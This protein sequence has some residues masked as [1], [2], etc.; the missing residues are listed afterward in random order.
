MPVISRFYGIVIKMY[1]R[2]AE[3]NPPHFH[4]IYGEFVGSIDIQTGEMLEGDLPRRALKIVQ[5]WAEQH[6][7][8]LL[9]MWDTQQITVLP[10]L[11]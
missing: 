4:A 8:E 9:T 7:S 3:H 1:F 2:Q 11:E 6:R 10:S 5:E